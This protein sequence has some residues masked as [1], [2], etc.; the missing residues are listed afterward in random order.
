MRI[1]YIGKN[2][3]YFENEK[4]FASIT[5]DE[6]K[7]EEKADKVFDILRNEGWEVVVEQGVAHIPVYDKGDYKELL[8]DYKQ[9]KKATGKEHRKGR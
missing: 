3:E 4:P 2:N 5:Y 8:V 9:A 7:E 1:E 6:V